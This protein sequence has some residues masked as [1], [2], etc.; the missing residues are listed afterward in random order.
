VV[1]LDDE[2]DKI[3]SQILNDIEVV[4][5][6]IIVYG[7]E[8]LIIAQEEAD[9]INNLNEYQLEAENWLYDGQMFHRYD[10]FTKAAHLLSQ[11]LELVNVYIPPIQNRLA[12]EYIY[13]EGPVFLER[14]P[15]DTISSFQGRKNELLLSLAIAYRNLNNLYC[16]KEILEDLINFTHT[17]G[18][19]IY[20]FF[21]HQFIY[22][23]ISREQLL[24]RAWKELGLI[25]KSLELYDNALEAFK[26]SLEAGWFIINPWM[27]IADIYHK[28]GD[29]KK[30][31]KAKKSFKV[32]EKQIRKFCNKKSI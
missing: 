28:L 17:H 13:I 12:H 3:K 25:Y 18:K 6:I 24:S 9:R 8:V 15:S 22:F 10:S 20:P 21:N 23:P 1:K 30:A 32:K 5:D 7:N 19:D 31:K 4:E 14:K 11:A 16:A 27:E 2:V 26:N 29:K